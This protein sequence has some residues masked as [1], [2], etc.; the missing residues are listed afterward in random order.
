MA[1]IHNQDLS[2]FAQVDG[3]YGALRASLW[4][5]KSAGEYRIGQ[6]TGL[7]AG[8]AA[9]TEIFQFRWSL[10]THVAAIKFI[11]VRYAV[12]AGFTAAQELAFDVIPAVS[13]TANGTLGT[14]IAPG[15]TNLK[16]RSSY[17][18]SKVADM[19]IAQ[20]V[21]LGAGTK[22][23]ST[24][25]LATTSAKTLAAAATVQDAQFEETIDMTN[26]GDAPLVLQQNEGFVVRNTILLGAGGTVRATVQ[27]AWAEFA[28]G[29]Y[30]SL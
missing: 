13:W 3:P 14:A 19:R 8:L 28:A 25:A 2:Q 6:S 27:V 16:K 7:L 9:N 15:A 22:T 4:P 21:A 30:P 24:H 11:K 1:S 18:D 29:D 12:V 17:V 23:L 26:S 5:Q 20:T 10:A